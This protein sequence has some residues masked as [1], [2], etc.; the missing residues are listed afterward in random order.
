MS[1]LPSGT[2]KYPLHTS[3][4]ATLRAVESLIVSLVQVSERPSVA[5]SLSATNQ[6]AVYHLEAGGQRVR[7]RLALHACESLGVGRE[8]AVRIAAAVELLH[9]ASLVHDDLQDKDK[10]RRGRPTVYAAFGQDVAICT[11]DLLLSAAYGALA[12]IRDATL[13]PSLLRCVHDRTSMVIQGQCAELATKD[14]SI[15]EVVRYERIVIGKSGALLSLP[16]ELAFLAAGQE[17]WVPRIRAA[18][19]A[20]GIGYQMVDDL[21]DVM[22]DAEQHNL[23][24]VLLLEAAGQNTSAV[25]QARRL[26]RHHLDRAAEIAETLPHQAGALLVEFAL[27]LGKRLKAD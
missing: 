21:A 15:T 11:G 27:D 9:N 16:I 23:N 19:H 24:I 1:I 22:A 13:L 26:A 5:E 6:A 10:L 7:A 18:A 4:D 12:E 20:F 3:T 14:F 17:H 2:V 25:G 8:D